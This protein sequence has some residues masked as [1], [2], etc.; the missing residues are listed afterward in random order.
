MAAP[1]NESELSTIPFSQQLRSFGP[2]YWIAN[3]MELV[4]RFAY[5]GVRVVLPV[6]MVAAFEKGGPELTQIQKGSI[7]AVWAVVQSFIPILSGG[8]ADRYGYKLNIALSTVLKIIGYI[9]MGYTVMLSEMAAGMPLSK[10]RAEGV[11][12]AYEIFFIGAMFLAFGT[13]I[14]KPGVQGLIANQMPKGSASLGWGL[15]YQM[16][17]IGGFIGPLLAGYLRVLQ[18]EYVF[19]ACAGGIALNFIPLFFF[20]EPERPE[21]DEEH[22]GP[23][24]LLYRALSGL[25]EPRLFFFTISFAGFWLMFYQ[26]FDILPN[27][28]DDWIDSRGPAA[29]LKEFFGDDVPFQLSEAKPEE[30][31]PKPPIPIVPTVN[32]GNLTQEWMINANALLISLF[33]FGVGYLTGRMKSLTAIVIG[34]GISAVAIYGLGMSMSGWWILGAICLFSCGEMMASP[35]KMRYL[36]SIAP[37]GREGLYMG[38]VNFTVGIGWSIGSIIAG[39]MYQEQGD[40]VELARR[41]LVEEKLA[42]ADKVSAISKNDLLPFFEKTVGVDAWKTR[43]ILWDK[44]EPYQMWKIFMLIG[45]GSMIAIIIYNKVVSAAEANPEHSLDTN[46]GFWVRAFL[47][48]ICLL[49]LVANVYDARTVSDEGEVS[50]GIPSLGLIL[51]ALFFWMMLS[52]SLLDENSRETTLDSESVS[53]TD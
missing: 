7:Y 40:K 51:N 36:A 2:I 41:Y 15:F 19:L 44:Y 16:V 22:A 12:N 42:T 18:W 38:Y 31:K 4:E 49:F 43:E 23:G 29:Q 46:G 6:F 37:P 8:F 17:N 5:Y 13:A 39:H 33:A 3:W 35:T 24:A 52:V 11:D 30:G 20:A 21:S 1:Q 28:I 50:W 34:I 25:L 53:D 32:G 10:A 26:L 14:F 9:I 27:F 45:V 47:I 48:P